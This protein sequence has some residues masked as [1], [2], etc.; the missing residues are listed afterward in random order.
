M[1]DTVN[2]SSI[3]VTG[4]L[5]RESEAETIFVGILASNF[6]KL[7]KDIKPQLR[8]SNSKYII[9]LN[10]STKTIKFL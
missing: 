9:D 8:N 5:E 1:R 4:V 3:L 6:A 7:M 10:I 2:K